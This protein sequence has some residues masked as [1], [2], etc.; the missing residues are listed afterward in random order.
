MNKINFNTPTTEISVENT[1]YIPLNYSRIIG[2]GTLYPNFSYIGLNTELR[3]LDPTQTE[4]IGNIPFITPKYNLNYNVQL[5]SIGDIFEDGKPDFPI[6]R[7]AFRTVVGSP[8]GNDLVT[9][10]VIVDNGGVAS[11]VGS[12]TD[13]VFD[14]EKYVW[15][16]GF[17]A[18]SL[19]APF[20]KISLLVSHPDNL[21]IE[22]Y[23]Y[24]LTMLY[25]QISIV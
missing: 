20:S 1:Q 24:S 10:S 21:T 25:N 13:Y 5:F 12:I 7:I 9:F 22:I 17:Q 23:P 16:I 4:I 8:T 11:V 19:L 2:G 18:V 14:E 15:D 3:V 6:I